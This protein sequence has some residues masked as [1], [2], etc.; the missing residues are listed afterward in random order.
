MNNYD[1]VIIDS[2]LNQSNT[3]V[4]GIGI[5]KEDDCYKFSNELQDDI[6]HGSI[7]YS[8]ISSKAKLS[9]IYIIKLPSHDDNDDSCLIEALRFIKEKIKC[10]LINISLGVKTG[11]NIK[12]LYNICYEIASTGTVIVAAFDNEGCYSYPAAFDC[13]LGV[14]SRNDIKNVS[15]FYFVENSP[16]NILGKGSIQRLTLCNGKTLLVGGASVACA[17]ITAFLANAFNEFTDINSALNYLKLK[18][19]YVYRSR[20]V[21]GKNNKNNM[22]K[23][24]NAVVFPFAKEAHAFVRFSDVLSFNIKGFY[25]VKHSG[26]V[27]RKLKSYYEETKNDKAIL[28]VENIDFKGVDTLILGHLDELSLITKRDYRSELIIKAID[29]NV[30]I[31]S[32]DPL[33]KYLNL[34][35]SSNIEFFYPQI[36]QCDVPENTFGKLYKIPTPVLGIF[37][38]SSQQGKFSLQLALKKELESLNYNVGTIG[39]EPHSLLFG[40]DVVFPMGYNSTVYLQ[41][42]EIVLYLNNEINNLSMKDKEI[43]LVASQAQFIPYYCNNLLEF[44]SVQ[45]HFS[46]GAKPDAAVLCFNFHDEISYIKNSMYALKGLTNASIVALVM[47]PIT[48]DNDWNGVYGCGKHKISRE[49]FESKAN[50]LYKEFGVP[51]FMLGGNNDSKLLC[52]TVIDFFAS[53]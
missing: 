20:K 10:K 29:S 37:G 48:Y 46:L 51:V 15:E 12:E 42:G 39:T 31:Y 14:D 27:G 24:T 4:E 34:L 28:D 6:G 45:Y 33:D 16:I 17:H 26:K 44:P 7:I 23:I 50:Q 13:V 49:E 8:L 36:N 53:E 21:E 1:I 9:N 32:F 5:I 40:F 18:S 38:T 52:Q 3:T 2:G 11:D 30:N 22:F 41:N 25:D 19:K 43:I 35:I 47:Y